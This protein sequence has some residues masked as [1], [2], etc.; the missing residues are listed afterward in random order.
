MTK[1]CFFFFRNPLKVSSVRCSTSLSTSLQSFSGGGGGG[2]SFGLDKTKKKLC[3]Y[4]FTLYTKIKHTICTYSF[5]NATILS[6]VLSFTSK[7]NS[8]S[9]V[10]KKISQILCQ[11]FPNQTRQLTLQVSTQTQM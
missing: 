2:G 5:I 7:A 6:A 11:F 8:P 4:Q 3:Q 1:T 9:L 10:I